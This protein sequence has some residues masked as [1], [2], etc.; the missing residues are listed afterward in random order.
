MLAKI[1]FIPF[2]GVLMRPKFST[3]A[4]SCMSSIL[5]S[6]DISQQRISGGVGGGRPRPRK[7]GGA[8]D[9][10]VGER[11]KEFQPRAEAWPRGRARPQQKASF[12]VPVGYGGSGD[13]SK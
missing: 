7:R 9:L 4:L 13:P 1:A 10:A 12:K 5:V 8:W 2:H 11:H 6:S 3:G